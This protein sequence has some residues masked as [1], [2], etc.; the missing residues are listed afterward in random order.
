MATIGCGIYLVLRFFLKILFKERL[1][2]G[3]VGGW[4]VS[5]V[6]LFIYIF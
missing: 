6:K 3:G 1:M 5:S 4:V 2:V